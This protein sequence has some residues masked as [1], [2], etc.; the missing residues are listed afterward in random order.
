MMTQDN[1]L[2]TQLEEEVEQEVNAEGEGYPI[3]HKTETIHFPWSILII[4]GVLVL[5]MVVCF[6]AILVLEG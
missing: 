5:L 2:K 3:D 6:I 4:C 1:D